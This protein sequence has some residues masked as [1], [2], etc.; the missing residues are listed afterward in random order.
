MIVYG[1]IDSETLSRI[2]YSMIDQIEYQKVIRVD[3]SS[4]IVITAGS[5]YLF[6]LSPI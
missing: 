5:K 4:E 1:K 6:H 2:F 3:N